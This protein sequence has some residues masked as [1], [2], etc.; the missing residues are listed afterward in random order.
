MRSS[1]SWRL[2]E[3]TAFANAA[4]F[5]ALDVR[6]GSWSSPARAERSMRESIPN[7]T[8]KYCAPSRNDELTV[9]VGFN[10]RCMGLLERSRVATTEQ[11]NRGLCA[12]VAR[13]RWGLLGPGARG[14]K[15]TAALALPLRG[16]TR[17]PRT[18]LF[19]LYRKQRRGRSNRVT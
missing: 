3:A 18:N 11:W 1:R 10:P 4:P 2:R 7:K 8:Q 6:T 16:R 15:P 12:G 13:R 19:L 14:L 5:I 17:I 9:A